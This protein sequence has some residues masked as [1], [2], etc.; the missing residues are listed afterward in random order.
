MKPEIM[1]INTEDR[2]ATME[3]IRHA[4]SSSQVSLMDLCHTEGNY[5]EMDSDLGGTI[6]YPA[7]EI[8]FF[9]HL[10]EMDED[11]AN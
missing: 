7:E 1:E 11:I 9:A 8:E 4:I 2:L 6:R 3:E 5:C 10:S